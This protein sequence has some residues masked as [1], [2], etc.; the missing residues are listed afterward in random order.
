[1]ETNENNE[2]QPPRPLWKRI[3]AEIYELLEAIFII[4][5]NILRGVFNDMR[6]QPRVLG[7]L[8]SLIVFMVFYLLFSWL[9]SNCEN[10]R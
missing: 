5:G 8:L 3:G 4:I 7:K 6:H 10:C 1:M 2:K 9:F